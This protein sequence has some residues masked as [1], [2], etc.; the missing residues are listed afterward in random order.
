MIL[1]TENASK[2]LDF[3][4][5]SCCNV[6]YKAISKVLA[7]WLKEVL[8]STIGK[9]QSAFVLGRKTTDNIFIAQ[10]L[11]NG[12]HRSGGPPRCAIKVDITKAYDTLHWDFLEKVLTC[13]EF[14]PLFRK[15][16]VQ[17]FSTPRFSFNL[18]G[19]LVGFISSYRGLRQEDLISPYLFLIAMEVLSFI[20]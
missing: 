18:N 16:L 7:M 14:P 20:F 1:K 15:L 12:Y 9:E 11:V 8:G 4:P 17:C 2:L 10:E 6:L 3:R 5:I 19:G 13:M